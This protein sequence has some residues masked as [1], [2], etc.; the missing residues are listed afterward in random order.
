ME[1]EK[2]LT[3]E[4]LEKKTLHLPIS[5]RFCMV[6]GEMTMVEAE[7]ADVPVALIACMILHSFGVPTVY[8]DERRLARE[9]AN[10]D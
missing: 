1:N 3:R 2:A 5:A 9:A 6:N 4:E 8:D 7:Y 10:H